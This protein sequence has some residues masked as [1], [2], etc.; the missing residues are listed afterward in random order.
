MLKALEDLSK[1]RNLAA[2]GQ[3]AAVVDYLS[4]RPVAELRKSPTL[5]LLL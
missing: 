2:T 1:V 4:D 3:Y 5:A